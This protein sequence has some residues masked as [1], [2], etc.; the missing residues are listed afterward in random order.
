MGRS[1]LSAIALTALIAP[2]GASDSS[3][4]ADD[5]RSCATGGRGQLVSQELVASYATAESVQA[6]FDEWVAFYQDYYLFPDIPVSFEYGYDSYKVS[7]CTVDAPLADRSTAEPTTATGMVSVPRKSGPLTTVAYLHGTSVSFY[8]APS[9]PNIFGE[10]SE[11]GESFDGPPS[12]AVFAGNGFLYI[13]PDYLG[14]G[15]SSVPRHR[16]FHAASEASSAVDLLAASQE[17]LDGLQVERDDRLFT[18]GFSQGGHS[19]LALQRELQETGVDVTATATVGAVFDVEQ[20]LLWSLTEAAAATVPLYVAYL[21]LAYDDIYD[22]YGETSDIFLPPYDSSVDGLF[23]MQHYFDDVAAA[24]ANV[25][26][27]AAQFR[28]SRRGDDRPTTPTACSPSRK[29]RRA[30]DTRCTSSCVSQRRRRRGALRERPRVRTASRQRRCRGVGRGA[31]R[32]RPCQQLAASDAAGGDL[33]P[34][35]RLT[36]PGPWLGSIFAIVV[37]VHQLS[38]RDARRIA[39]RAEML[40]AERPCGMVDMVRRLTMVQIDVTSAVAPSADLVA[41]SRLGQEYGLG[42]L[43]DAVDRQELIS[44]QGMIRPPEDIALHRADME[45]WRTGNVE[46]WRLGNVQWVNDNDGCRRDILDRLRADGPLTARDLPDTCVRPWRSSG[47]NNNRNVTLLLEQM[48]LRGEV[49]AAG[50]SEGGKRLWDLADRIYGDVPTVPADEAR[51]IRDEKRLRALGIARA[52]ATDCP[53]ERNDVGE[54]GEPAVIDGVRGEWRAEPTQLGQP[55]TG[56]LA[57]L[58]PLD[59]LVY[60]RKRMA[61]V[62]E[63]DYQLEMF[64]PKAKRRWGYYAL[65]ILC[66]DRLVGKVDATTDYKSGVLRVDA[67][68]RDTDLTKAQ[69]ADLDRELRDLAAWLQVDLAVA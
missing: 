11:A 34:N 37:E 60:D 22:I 65:P 13:A 57:L 58:S 39:V 67:I 44:L 48:E 29:L 62:F 20:W 1:K 36:E 40:G 19:A 8:D 49:A 53:V 66:G 4:T 14:L 5:V 16:Y 68:H 55:F 28:V 54:T 33:V 10:L 32:V 26:G 30:V 43:E 56:R 45:D 21:L 23:D 38:R 59:R 42:D 9:N 31:S 41:W 46:G 47:W 6:Y 50:R 18:F 63:F 52:R 15:G 3:G 17:L 24:S 69:D 64:K 61:E 2:A 51:R 25:S 35:A 27:R 12:S 7:Y